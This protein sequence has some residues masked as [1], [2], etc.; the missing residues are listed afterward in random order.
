MKFLLISPTKS[1]EFDV[2]WIEAQTELSNFVVKNGHEP[3]IAILANN[4]E[5]SLGLKD[6][7]TTV[8]T[9]SG[10]ILKVNRDNVMLLLKQE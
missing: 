8:M 9:I 7:S 1:K 5:L 4:K 6:G 3:F 10:G 2:D